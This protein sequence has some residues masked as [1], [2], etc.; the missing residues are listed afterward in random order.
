MPK[1]REPSNR[2]GV[3]KSLD[4][5]PSRY[6]LESYA[7]TYAGR[8]TWAEYFEAELSEAAETVQYESELAE[9]S[10]KNHMDER[11]RHHA[12]ATPADVDRWAVELL[13]R[14][15]VSRAYNPYW[16]RLEKFYS[17]LLWHTDHPHVYHPPRI[18]AAR[19]GAAADIWKAKIE[20][21]P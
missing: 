20:T 17:Y 21:G 13:D 3:Y 4:D 9:T 15:Q 14:M 1:S 18:A 2:I 8:D 6:R 5:V 10:W 19:G 11:G 7:G 16:V 12:L